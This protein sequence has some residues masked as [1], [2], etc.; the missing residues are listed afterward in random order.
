METTTPGTRARKH[1]RIKIGRFAPAALGLLAAVTASVCVSAPAAAVRP[2][3]SMRPLIT[4]VR[5]HDGR[6]WSRRAKRA[7]GGSPRA[8]AAIVGGNPITIAQVPWQVVV[9]A[10]L[11]PHVVLICGGSILNETEILTAGHCMYN[12][13]T[14]ERIAPGRIVVGAGSED[15]EIEPEQVS[16]A[17][18]VRV[19]P[20]YNPSAPLPEPDDVAVLQLET[21]LVFNRDVQSIEP[22]MAGSLFSEGTGVS[23]S[24]FGREQLEEPLNGTLNGI[25]M[26]LR[27]SRE[28][29][30]EAA[31]LFLCASS[32]N[33]SPCSGDSGSGL[34]VPGTPV[35]LAGVD[36]VG[37]VVDGKPCQ[38]GALAGYA[39][40][41]AP[42]IRDFVMA[43]DENPP[44][45]PRGGG[46]VI[47]G[48]PMSGNTLN[49]EP[50]GWSNAPTFTYVFVNSSEGAVLQRGASS[51]YALTTADIGRSILCEALATNAG[52]TGVGRTPPLGVVTTNPQEEAAKRKRTEE[53]AA[54]RKHAE[55]EQANDHPHAEEPAA[56]GGVLS[57]KETAKPHAHTHA[58]LLAK[59][60][61][62]CKKQPRHR[63]AQCA[64]RARRRYGSKGSRGKRK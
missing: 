60:L 52:G 24:G 22:I 14:K 9:I 61:V 44:R 54:A 58:Q 20:Y 33:G 13:S 34:T 19:H 57:A 16:V 35:T 38:P 2:R 51:T 10:L 47:R 39:N 3:S 59:A 5:L 31:A 15:I 18:G 49:C 62:A 12:P 23:L 1:R 50:G 46:A 8:R 30:G 36:D 28:C 45:A 17:A 48:V 11:E 4:R 27:S 26:T 53:E 29:G 32:P 40:V 43:G 41:A 6:L 55:E 37:Q 42:E 21:P 56:K 25:G 63:R 64:A 7:R